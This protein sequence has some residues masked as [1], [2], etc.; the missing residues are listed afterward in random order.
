MI[1]EKMGD[2][3]GLPATYIVNLAK[4]ASYEY[5]EYTIAKRSGGH[6]II[7]HPSR[8]LKAL[9][10]WLLINVIEQLPVHPCATAYRKGKSIFD[11][12]RAHASSRYLLRMD[13]NNF[14][15]SITELDL[16]RYITQHSHSFAKWTSADI[17]CFCRLICRNGVL[18]I[19]APTS[20]GLSNAICHDL[21]VN[22]QALS[23]A[24]GVVY[25]RYADDLF[26]STEEVISQEVREGG[27]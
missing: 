4:G 10:R 12:A 16:T 8:R 26:F 1:V 22:L 3:L 15:P 7:Q 11:N 17:Q 27:N 20:P 13:F 14:F 23:E 25:T 19:G 6:R 21:D 18:T 5:K 24:R 2:Q 9:Q